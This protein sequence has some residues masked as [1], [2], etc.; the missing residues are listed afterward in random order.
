MKF[1][2]ALISRN[3][4]VAVAGALMLASQSMAQAVDVTASVTELGTVK[5][6]VIA[7]GVAVLSIVIGIKLYK[8]V[9][10]AL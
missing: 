8:W 2:P 9:T 7:V 10:R 1:S 5:T 3:I 4:V 6:A